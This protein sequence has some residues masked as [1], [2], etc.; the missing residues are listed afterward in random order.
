MQFLPTPEQI[1][2]NTMYITFDVPASVSHAGRARCMGKTGAAPYGTD[3]RG[4]DAVG[5]R[6]ATRRA[7]GLARAPRPDITPT[8]GATRLHAG[9]PSVHISGISVVLFFL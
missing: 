5:T 7:V 3:K 1:P 2:K 9:R 6:S 4:R 8:E